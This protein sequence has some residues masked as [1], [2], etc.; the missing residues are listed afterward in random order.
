VADI[1]LSSVRLNGEVEPVTDNQYGFVR[2]PVEN[3]TLSLKLPRDEVSEVLEIGGDV[4]IYITAETKEQEILTGLDKTRVIERPPGARIPRCP[5]DGGRGP[6]NGTPE[7]GP[8]EEIPGEGPDEGPGERVGPTNGT[9][10]RGPPE[11][12]PGRGPPD[13]PEEDDED[14]ENEEVGE[15]ETQGDDGVDD[16]RNAGRGEEPPRNERGDSG[17][18]DLPD[19]EKRGDSNRRRPSGR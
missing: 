4:T 6:P 18:G 15:N 2:N 13:C 5:P 17:R 11:E 19:N 8:P 14:G 9:P 7:G 12:V 16:R 1:N 10:G 3:G